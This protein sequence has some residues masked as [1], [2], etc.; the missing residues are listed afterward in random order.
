MFDSIFSS[1]SSTASTASIPLIDSVLTILISFIL[2]VI[3]SL[4][5]MKTA[6]NKVYSQNFALTLIIVPMV[7]AIIVLLIGSNV[8][9]AFSLAGAFSIIRF[10]SAPGNSKDISFV[11]FTMA[12]GLA[13]GVGAYSYAILFTVFLCVLMFVLSVI[14][15]GGRKVSSMILKIT[16][17]EDLDYEGVFDE[18]FQKYT[19]SH[20]LIKVKTTDLGSLFQLIFTI[21]LDSNKSQKEFLDALR[22][23]NGNLNITLSLNEDSS[24]Y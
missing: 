2:G 6:Q 22:C 19:R 11:L 12:A 18:V 21:T 3:I 4:T 17:P 9:R 10:R 20:E 8:A 24:E 7:I 14:N 1:I 13:C 23:R 5:Y 15:F 16:I